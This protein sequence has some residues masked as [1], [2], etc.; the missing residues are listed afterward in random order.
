MVLSFCLFGVLVLARNLRGAPPEWQP[1]ADS[2]QLTEELIAEP[3]AGVVLPGLRFLIDF[4]VVAIG[5][6]PLVVRERIGMPVIAQRRR[7]LAQ[8]RCQPAWP[9]GY[10][11]QVRGDSCR[12]AARL[13]SVIHRG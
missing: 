13:R 12:L 9:F 6:G 10:S 8:C 1:A 3:C 2:A 11:R 5:L 7:R 4:V